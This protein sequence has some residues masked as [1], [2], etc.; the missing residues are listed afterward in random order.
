MGLVGGEDATVGEGEEGG[1][2]V[3]VALEFR[4]ERGRVSAA[5]AEI[6][7]GGVDIA[8]GAGAAS[9][10]GHGAEEEGVADDDG[11]LVLEPAP[12]AV[13]FEESG[14][15][16]LRGRGGGEC[17]AGR[18]AARVR[19]T[20][21]RESGG[22]WRKSGGAGA[23]NED[24]NGRKKAQEAQRKAEARRGGSYGVRRNFRP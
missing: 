11:A 8:G 5:G 16:E 3:I 7:S 14:C 2:V 10:T 9:G 13:G 21:G 12:A 1:D 17:A 20:S 6:N 15:G 4:M 18:N 22:A 19:A 24:R 23:K